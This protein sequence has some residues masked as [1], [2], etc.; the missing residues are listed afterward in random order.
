[1]GVV[2]GIQF[3]NSILIIEFRLEQGKRITRVSLS[4]TIAQTCSAIII[5]ALLLQK[6]KSFWSVGGKRRESFSPTKDREKV[7]IPLSYILFRCSN[8]ELNLQV[9]TVGGCGCTAAVVWAGGGI[10]RRRQSQWVVN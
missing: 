7:Y 8:V 9:R 10:R 4:F 1:M 6:K 3:R 5:L 2:E